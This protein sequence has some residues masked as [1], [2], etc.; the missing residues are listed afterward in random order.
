MYLGILD[1]MITPGPE[2]HFRT[3]SGLKMLRRC[4]L[5]SLTFL[6][7]RVGTQRFAST[8]VRFTTYL[9]AV[10]ILNSVDIDSERGT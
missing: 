4:T 9:W 5:R 7:T 1:A 10:S 3:K 2:A 6:S 8:K